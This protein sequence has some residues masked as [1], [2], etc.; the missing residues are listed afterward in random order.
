MEGNWQ[1][2]IQDKYEAYSLS[3]SKQQNRIFWLTVVIALSTAVYTVTTWKSVTAM[4]ESN[5]IQ[6]QLLQLELN[7]QKEH[8]K[9]VK[10]D[11]QKASRVLP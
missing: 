2:R 3:Q 7:K 8:N 5:D 1:K 10:N 11:A 4:N 6:K 9:P